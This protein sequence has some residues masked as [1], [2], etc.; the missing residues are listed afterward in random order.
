MYSPIVIITLGCS[1]TTFLHLIIL[2][3]ESIPSI[4]L[5]AVHRLHPLLLHPL[6]LPPRHI[7]DLDDTNIQDQD[8][9]STFRPKCIRYNPPGAP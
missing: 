8:N 7:H 3:H 4:T 1:I 5:L 9:F 2:K 6:L